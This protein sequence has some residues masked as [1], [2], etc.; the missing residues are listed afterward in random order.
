MFKFRI[1][2]TLTSLI[3]DNFEHTYLREYNGY[4]RLQ[5]TDYGTRIDFCKYSYITTLNII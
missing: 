1:I 2:Q 4:S 3:K 5:Q